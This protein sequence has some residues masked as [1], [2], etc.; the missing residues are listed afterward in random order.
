[1]RPLLLFGASVI[2]AQQPDILGRATERSCL[3]AD[4]ATFMRLFVSGSAPLPPQV[5]L[6]SDSTIL[7]RYGMSETLMNIS[8]PYLGERRPGTLGFPQPDVPVQV[9]DEESRVLPDGESGELFAR[10]FKV[11][12]NF[13]RSEALP[14]TALGKIQRHLLVRI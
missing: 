1:M 10:S 8:N 7:V 12:R 4:R 9:R 14:R 3:S 11:P 6:N 5:L 13:I 2:N